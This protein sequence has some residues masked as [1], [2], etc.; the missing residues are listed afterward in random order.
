MTFSFEK[1]YGLLIDGQ[2]VSAEN[3]AVFDTFNP[4]T[5]E[6]LS[7][8]ANASANDVDRAVKAAQEA[9]KTWSKTS[10]QDRAQLLLKAAD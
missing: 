10:P 3:K 5:G 2:W 9:F 1:E 6:L 4:A 7:S 8:C